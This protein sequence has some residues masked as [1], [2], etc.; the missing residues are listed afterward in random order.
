[1]CISVIVLKMN[2]KNKQFTECITKLV[3]FKDN[4]TYDQVNSDD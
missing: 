1:M 4:M 2:Y 3:P